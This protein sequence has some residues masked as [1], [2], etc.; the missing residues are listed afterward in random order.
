MIPIDYCICEEE[1]KSPYSYH[2]HLENNKMRVY[3][4]HKSDLITR[5]APVNMMGLF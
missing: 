3:T 1:V 2:Q 5:K 4:G